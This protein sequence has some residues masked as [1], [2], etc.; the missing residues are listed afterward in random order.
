MTSPPN[1]PRFVSVCNLIVI[2]RRRPLTSAYFS[3]TILSRKASVVD[4]ISDILQRNDLV[5]ET[6]LTTH[7]TVVVSYASKPSPVDDDFFFDRVIRRSV[8][9][10]PISWRIGANRGKRNRLPETDLDSTT[11]STIGKKSRSLVTLRIRVWEHCSEFV[12]LV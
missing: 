3:C 11:R 1:L 5:L 4:C 8:L 7:G 2:L 12:R 10:P 6:L 9:P